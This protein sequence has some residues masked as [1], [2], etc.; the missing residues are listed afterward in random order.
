[1]A[2]IL[3]LLYKQVIMKNLLSIVLLAL[4][5]FE[6]KAQVS[7]DFSVNNTQSCGSLQA[8]FQ[9][10]STS[11]EGNI[12]AW[13]WDLAGIT[14][15]REK[16][17]RIFDTPGAYTICLEVTDSNGNTGRSCK[18]D[19]INIY[20]NPSSNFKVDLRKGCSP[21][22]VNFTDL[23]TK[24]G[25]EIV[26]WTWD[27]GGKTNFIKTSDPNEIIST[28]YEN[29]GLYSVALSI[30]DTNGCKDIISKKDFIDIFTTPKVILSREIVSFCDFPWVV[31]IKNENVDLEATYQWDF[32]N[33]KTFD[34]P[35]PPLAFYY[36]KGAYDVSVTVQ[37]GECIDTFTFEGYI[38]TDLAFNIERDVSTPCVG[39][40]VSFKDM[41]EIAIDS[42]FWDFGDGTTS[43]DQNPIK[44]FSNTG[45]FAIKVTRYFDD[46]IIT[47]S[48]PCIEVKALP[49]VTYDID[50]QFACSIPTDI[51]VKGSGQG[52]Y[53]WKMVNQSGEEQLFD[54]LNSKFTLIE[55]GKYYIDVSYTDLNGCTNVEEKVLINID[56]FSAQLPNKGPGGCVPYFAGLTDSIITNVGIKSYAWEIPKM[57]YTSTEKSPF[58]Y[59]TDTGRYDVRLIVE[60]IY[61]CKD[62]IYKVGYLQGGTPPTVDFEATPTE[63]CLSAERK[64]TS[65][66]STNADY[67]IWDFGDESS[68]LLI[69]PP[70]TYSKIGL[71]D[72]S[73]TAFHNGCGSSLVKS[74]YITIQ[75]PISQYEVTY[76][77]EDP[78]TIALNNLSVG[79]DSIY[80]FIQNTN[81]AADTI[82]DS[83]LTSFTFPNTGR[84]I[85]GVYTK[86][87]STGCEHMRSDTLDIVDLKP[88]YLADTLTGCRPLIINFDYQVD[89]YAMYTLLAS[90]ST[91]IIED[92]M[93][94]YLS[95]GLYS[96]PTL[97]LEDIHGCIKTYQDTNIVMVGAV[98]T[99]A[100]FNDIVCV[101]DSVSFLNLSTSLFGSL[102]TSVWSISDS[103]YNTD[104]VYIFIEKVGMYD[105]QL[106]VKDDW[107]CA[108]SLSFVFEAIDSSLDFSADT[109]G[110]LN[111]EI[112]FIPSNQALTISDYFWDFGDGNTSTD[113]VARHSYISEGSYTVCLTVSD[114]RGCTNMTCKTDYISIAEPVASFTG[115]PLLEECPPLISDFVNTSINAVKYE[116]D[117]GDDSGI[118]NVDQPSHIYSEPGIFDVTLIAIRSATCKDTLTLSDYVEVQGPKGEFSY[119]VL[120]NCTPLEVLFT[121]SSDRYYTYLWDFGNGYIDSSATLMIQDSLSISYTE[122]GKYTPKLI[123]TDDNGCSRTFSSDPVFVNT[124]DPNFEATNTPYCDVPVEIEIINTSIT[125]TESINYE[126]FLSSSASTSTYFTDDLFVEIVELGYYDIELIGMAENCTDTL[127]KPNYLYIS[128]KPQV[129]FNIEDQICEGVDYFVENTSSIEEGMISYYDWKLNGKTIS[130][131]AFLSLNIDEGNYLLTLTIGSASGCNGEFSKNITVLSNPKSE[132]AVEDIICIGETGMLKAKVGDLNDIDTYLWSDGVVDL[133]N[134]CLEISVSPI[135]TSQYYF[136]T[137]LTNG[138]QQT[139]SITL[140]VAPVLP[141]SVSLTNDTIICNGSSV[142]IEILDYNSDYNYSWLNEGID[143]VE[144]DCINS[145]ATPTNDTSYTIEATN[146]Y[147][148]TSQDTIDVGVEVSIPD[149]LSDEK[150][151]C[152]DASTTLMGTSGNNPTWYD[153]GGTICQGCDSINIQPAAPQYYYLQV[154]SDIGCTYKDSILVSLVSLT[155]IDAGDFIEICDGEEIILNGKGEGIATWSPNINDDIFT[156]SVSPNKTTTYVLTATKEECQLIDSVMVEVIYKAEVFAEGDT[157]CYG[158][159][160]EISA[161]GK[162]AAFS[163][164]EDGQLAFVNESI[165][166]QPSKSKNLMVIGSRTTCEDDTAFV[167]FIV[168]PKIDYNIIEDKLVLFANSR[169][170]LEV[171]YDDNANYTYQWSSMEGL[172]C[173]DCPQPLVTNVIQ[174]SDYIVTVTDNDTGC[175]I[176]QSISVLVKEECNKDGFFIPNV[177]SPNNDGQND[178]FSINAGN[179]EEFI[180]IIIM[181]R[182]GSIILRSSDPE[183][184]WRGDFNGQPLDVGVFMYV[185]NAYCPITGQEYNFGGDITLIK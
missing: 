115:S 50:N 49:A 15:D 72:V 69:N 27:I 154:N 70:H 34:G 94:R 9:D 157:V 85:I 61:N 165:T 151:I 96:L 144:E 105:G 51:G 156:P 181:D 74:E 95:A 185:I 119:D 4:I 21:L 44:A 114:I 65:I 41:T 12:V 87:D 98:E 80:W 71:F 46:C 139:D 62:T 14:S 160:G 173:D 68:S 58:I 116:W 155:S 45:C 143:C 67:W 128:S 166:I 163:W 125:N 179:P 127:V 66:T 93:A 102:T 121:A 23:S 134:N 89:D 22:E 38:N 142:E 88:Y 131:Q 36:D 141:P 78:Y 183:F 19:F 170:L 84:H 64:F 75:E 164:Y 13:N 162:A 97:R 99:I 54:A 167:D 145:L 168:H 47:E 148:C 174:N 129:S 126:W 113:V 91:S 137:I 11:T 31:A 104:S 100:D 147:G 182:W 150:F 24:S 10:I 81:G 55:Y 33:G 18:Q 123:I 20:Q 43:F 136:T 108:D 184:Q 175:E 169:Q 77:C 122:S 3:L 138:C 48:Y 83:I 35:T 42:I 5:F 153:Q 101:P 158:D 124:I 28:V 172:S 118:S 29:E 37:K 60:N 40:E 52:Y 135:I 39:E 59:V 103:I 132:L 26:S 82:R 32:G 30:E 117:F 178:V 146:T 1:M 8:I 92:T 90:D 159:E 7:V 176:N 63:G 6:L 57:N 106:V 2:R 180:G 76:N 16:P 130:N 161:Y 112:V 171:S 17:G 86:S 53:D 25:S 133:C 79:A 56:E 152:Q 110:C 107:N 111:T 73:L 140:N 120:G 109:F 177:F 149:F